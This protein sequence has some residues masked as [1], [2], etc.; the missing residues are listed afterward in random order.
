ME[1][2]RQQYESL[3]KFIEFYCTFPTYETSGIHHY[4]NYLKAV[5]K[6]RFKT[7]IRKK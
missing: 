1:L 6:Q 4:D 3:N 5:A 7:I 2:S